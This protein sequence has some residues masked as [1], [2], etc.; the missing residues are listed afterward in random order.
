MMFSYRAISN[1]RYAPEYLYLF[2]GLAYFFINLIVIC[3]LI[4]FTTN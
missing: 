1:S 3:M 2:W 4:Y